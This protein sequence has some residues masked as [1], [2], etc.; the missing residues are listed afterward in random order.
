MVLG[1]AKIDYCTSHWLTARRSRLVILAGKG[2][3]GRA[4]LRGEVTGAG[5]LAE[6]AAGR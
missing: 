1:K 5:D 4:V 6:A 2:F 3:A